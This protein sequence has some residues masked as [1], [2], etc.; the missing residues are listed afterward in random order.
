MEL[1]ITLWD[2]CFMTMKCWRY[3]LI[4]KTRSEKELT[5]LNSLNSLSLKVS[6]KLKV[7][8]IWK[9]VEKGNA[10]GLVAR[11]TIILWDWL[12]GVLD[13][14]DVKIITIAIY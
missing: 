14:T 4:E 9:G 5:D 13:R 10:P 2:K 1:V 6:G 7:N 8:V 3:R 12:V 11:T